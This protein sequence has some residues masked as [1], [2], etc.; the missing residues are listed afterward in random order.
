MLITLN[1]SL[2]PPTPLAALDP[3]QITR[4]Y[5]YFHNRMQR[6]HRVDPN[7]KMV[8][9]S[10][11]AG[12][13]HFMVNSYMEVVSKAYS[14]HHNLEV[15]PHDIWYLVLTQIAELVKLSPETYRDLFTKSN[16]KILL[17]VQ[18]NHATDLD[19]PAIMEQM[20]QFLPTN[21]AIFLPE[22]STHTEGSK[23]ACMAAFADGM[24]KYYE[25][26]MFCCGIP[27]ISLTGTLEDWEQLAYSAEQI[28]NHFGHIKALTG[29][30]YIERVRSVIRE[31]IASYLTPHMNTAFWT[32]I[33]TQRNVGSGGDLI[34]N[35]WM[36]DLYLDNKC[37]KMMRSCHSTVSVVPYS[38]LS[39]GQQ[40]VMM[41]GAFKGVIRPDNVL[42]A[43][44]GHITFEIVKKEPVSPNAPSR[45]VMVSNQ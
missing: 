45:V 10:P 1:D 8:V 13:Y 7:Q 28:S 6:Q 43:Q 44:Y 38:N 27:K 26:G 24:Q 3:A 42:Q 30:T 39:T 5:E 15:A 36:L 19:L 40:Y 35:G 34:V 25:Y 12:D 22:L 17:A 20:V 18:Q 9:V 2:S 4:S 16:D 31:I 14:R 21:M 23:L 33:F 32:D 29:V 41:H 11:L 37:E